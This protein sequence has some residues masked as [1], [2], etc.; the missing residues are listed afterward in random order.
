[1]KADGSGLMNRIKDNP[2]IAALVAII[3]LSVAAMG[4]ITFVLI[5]D[6]QRDASYQ[7]SIGELR[8]SSFQLTSLSRDATAGDDA[9]F[10][11]LE[12]VVSSM[13]SNWRR[14]LIGDKTT[15]ALLNKETLEFET[16][17]KSVDENAKTILENEETILFLHNVANTLN[18]AIPQLQSE[19]NLIVEILLD[20][21]APA[22]QVA[23]AQMQSWRAERIGRNV[24]K[25]LRGGGDADQA[26]DQFNLDANLFGK[27]L[28]GML[29]GDAAMDISRI[30]DPEALESLSS[31]NDLFSVVS[32]QV[33]DIFEA[34][35]ALFQARQSANA[36][37]DQNSQV[38]EGLAA[39]S[40]GIEGLPA[41]RKINTLVLIAVGAIG[42]IAL[43][44]LIFLINQATRRRLRVTAETNDRNQNAILRLLD[45]LADLADGD[46]TT[47][48][49]VTEDFTGAIADSVNYTIDQ[50]RILVSRINET[51]ERVVGSSSEAQ[52]T[53]LHLAEAAEHQAQ[54]IAGASAAINEMAV[55]S[56]RYR[57]T[58]LSRRALRRDRYR[59]RAMVPR[60]YEIPLT[61][62]IR[63][64]SRFRTRQNVSNDW[65]NLLRRLGISLA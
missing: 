37:L 6:A 11:R 54:E 17:W 12:S 33:R 48:A 15:R 5:Q 32:G 26:A 10:D 42:L 56:T 2:I 4:Y 60:W 24:D 36:I 35:P 49:T 3:V 57:L 28:Q 64:A 65:V 13:D 38:L 1:M 46:L 34:S 40:D 16:A 23:V 39:L 14:M 47:T 25:M 22:D 52:Q 29:N 62:W 21:G 51:S 55:P 19:H 9:A 27:I 41:Q 53:A 18:Q 43:F 58:P 63:F 20:N 61:V 8:A 50:L 44:F 59:S 45:E 7:E 31:V 30:T